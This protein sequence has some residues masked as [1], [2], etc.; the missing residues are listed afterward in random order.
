MAK[1]KKCDYPMSQY[2]T[3][4]DEVPAGA[5]VST[6]EDCEGCN[7]YDG[8]D[9][10]HDGHCLINESSRTYKIIYEIEVT[11]NDHEQAALEAEDCMK[12]G[13]YRP[14]FKVISDRTHEI[15]EIDLEGSDLKL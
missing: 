10:R 1:R 4:E 12:N 5:R 7:G 6:P 2:H 8:D 13:H 14:H 15:K 11:A 9:C 3:Y